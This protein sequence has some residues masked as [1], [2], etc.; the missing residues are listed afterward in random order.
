MRARA[1]EGFSM[2][3]D[4]RNSSDDLVARNK[5]RCDTRSV[6]LSLGLAIKFEKHTRVS[7]AKLIST[8]IA[9]EA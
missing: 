4:S 2:K 7:L 9:R 1:N 5:N 3:D 8:S 6:E